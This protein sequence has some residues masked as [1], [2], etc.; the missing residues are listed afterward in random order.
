MRS[1]RSDREVNSHSP[2]S[3]ATTTVFN[4]ASEIA[5]AMTQHPDITQVY[6]REDFNRYDVDVERGFLPADDPLTHFETDHG[7]LEELDRLG[8]TLPQKLENDELRGDLQD[9]T[10][11]D[12]D[13][14]DDLDER[15]LFRVYQVSS[16]LASAYVHKTG[17]EQKD[18][19][20][21]G[22]AKP[23]YESTER[24][25]VPP[26]LSFDAYS[27]YN[28]ER[29][30]FD[31]PIELENIDTFQNFVDMEDEP[32]FMLIHTEIEQEAADALTAIPYLARASQ[33][34]DPETAKQALQDMEHATAE[35]VETL[36][37]MPEHNSPDVYA[38][39]DDGFRPYIEGFED[40]EYRG[41][42]ELDGPQSF[43]GET[44]AQ[45]TIM[46]ALDAA[47]DI[48]HDT[49]VLTQHIDDMR[50]YM[51]EGHRNFVAAIEDGPEVRA[52]IEQEDDEELEDLYNSTL[53]N[54]YAFREIHLNYAVEY[55][56]EKV[57]DEIGTG[58]TDFIQFLGDLK[59]ETGKSAVTDEPEAMMQQGIQT[60]LER[61]KD[62]QQL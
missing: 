46:P 27:L 42:K 5:A 53:E 41:V 19:I 9:L 21:A 15:E 58:G 36:K 18:H 6:D 32:W 22:V 55:I 30:D 51:P 17:A 35:M 2:A 8:H 13:I 29:N 4:L 54:I 50:E 56:L 38:D 1:E 52:F 31:G 7:Y 16:F 10:P 48:S 11:P 47:L 23:L 49:N 26:I 12:D 3:G 60:M 28:F 37:R 39:E 24:L 57:G 34:G 33:E 45:S 59:Q 44:G 40:I 14:Y 62:S 25:N 43:R 20:P 61:E